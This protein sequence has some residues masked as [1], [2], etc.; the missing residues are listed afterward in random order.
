[1]YRFVMANTYSRASL[2]VLDIPEAIMQNGLVLAVK[3]WVVILYGLVSRGNRYG[4]L[5]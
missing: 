4:P 5:M 1:M 2:L 3:K